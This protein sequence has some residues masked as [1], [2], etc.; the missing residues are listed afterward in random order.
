MCV[1]MRECVCVCMRE[2]VCVCMRE[3]VCVCMRECVCVCM[4]ECVCACVQ[5]NLTFLHEDRRDGNVFNIMRLAK[6]IDQIAHTQ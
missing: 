3:C 4:R 5:F 1:C 6:V 2:C